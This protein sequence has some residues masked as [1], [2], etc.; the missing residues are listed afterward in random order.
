MLELS[1]A[2]G[3]V[4]NVLGY[5]KA[6]YGVDVITAVVPP[7][8]TN[9]TAADLVAP[10][11]AALAAD[12]RLGAPRRI[13]LVTVSHITSEPAV[14]LP[15]ERIAAVCAAHGVSALRRDPNLGHHPL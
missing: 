15:V 7:L 5:M 10:I 12:N 14:V 2:Y 9:T 13:K 3:M 4:K 1:T 11:A 8:S 6:A